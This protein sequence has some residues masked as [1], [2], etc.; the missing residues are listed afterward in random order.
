MKRLLQLNFGALL[1]SVMIFV[2]AYY[3][4]LRDNFLHT[5]IASIITLSETVKL[6]EHLLILGLLPIY[7]GTMI[8]GA[9][10]IGI[11]LGSSLQTVVSRTVRPIKKPSDKNYP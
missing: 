10:L 5:S 11:Y 9:A 3:L 6:K 8:F 7:I 2:I 1:T 4:L